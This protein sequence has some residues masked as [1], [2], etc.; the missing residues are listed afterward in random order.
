MIDFLSQLKAERDALNERIAIIEKAEQ[1]AAY[2]ACYQRQLI[3]TNED[4]LSK[5]KRQ[6]S[7]AEFSSGI[8]LED[9]TDDRLKKTQTKTNTLSGW[10]EVI[11]EMSNRTRK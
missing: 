8:L 11:Q 9:E 3:A 4:R 2:D 10:N 1:K 6:I 5:G 7:M